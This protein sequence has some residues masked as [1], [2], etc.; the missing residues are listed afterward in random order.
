MKKL[1]V[2]AGLL[3]TSIFATAQGTGLE[4][5]I[6]EKYY[7]SDAIDAADTDGGTLALGS[8]TYRIFVDMAPG[9]ILQSVYADQAGGHD[10]EFRTT[11]EFFNNEDRG[12]TTANSIAYNR[13]PDN[14]VMLDTWISMGAASAGSIGVLKTDDTN[15]AI[16]NSDGLLQNTDARAGIPV[17]TADGIMLAPPG[18]VSVLG[19]DLSVFDDVNA[20]PALTVADGA[21]YNAP[22]VSGYDAG[23]NIVL[24]GQFTTNGTFSYRFNMQLRRQSDFVVENWVHSNPKAV[25]NL[26]AGCSSLGVPTNVEAIQDELLKKSNKIL[27]YPNPA[28]DNIYLKVSDGMIARN[29]VIQVIN[30]I[31]NSVFHESGIELDGG[32]KRIDISSFP[33]GLYLIKVVSGEGITTVN[34]F[35]K[36]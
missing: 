23:S 29:C 1:L 9:Y 31:G 21:W 33:V 17:K 6:I 34:R 19:L 11:T 2:C 16:I 28:S 27:V 32:V 18:N 26:C 12:S 25:E 15:G 7:V 24:I 10:M 3:I 14:T 30:V 20:G 8:F 35:I 4:N 22:G 36:K 13:L 5:I